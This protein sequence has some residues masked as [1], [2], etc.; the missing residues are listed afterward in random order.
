M[1][2][3][4]EYF[5]YNR[6]HRMPIP[7]ELGIR[8]EARLLLPLVKS[9]QRFQVGESGEGR[10]LRRQAA[11]TRD[12]IYERCI[13]LFIKEEQEH[14]RLMAEILQNLGAPLLEHHW[15]D[16][17]FVLLRRLF[18]LQHELLVLLIPEM[19]AQIY[20]QVLR[21]GTK[22]QVLRAVFTQILQDEDG[23][24]AFHVAFLR[25]AFRKMALPTQVAT[26]LAWRIFFR[27]VC[28]V[29]MVDHY[30]ALRACSVSPARFWWDC[31]LLFDRT[32]AAIYGCT[33]AP[34]TNSA[35]A[36]EA[37]D[38]AFTGGGATFEKANS[39]A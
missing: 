7:W 35:K 24:V 30:S 28:L 15:S 16:A 18:N 29:V 14:A 2:E 36:A 38:L 39:N 25:R 8:P 10:H 12:E 6:D 26:R 9:L 23:H 21:D 19:I 20:F 31:G 5:E 11:S 37:I 13:D 27:G 22:D 3:W 34:R 32:A 33:E 17:C 4:L 1:N